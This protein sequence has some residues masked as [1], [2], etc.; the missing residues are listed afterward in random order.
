[1]KRLILFLSIATFFA[2]SALAQIL[3]TILHQNRV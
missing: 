2:L 1:M 3:M